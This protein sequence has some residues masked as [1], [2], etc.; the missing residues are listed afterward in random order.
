[1]PDNADLCSENK[2]RKIN[3]NFVESSFKSKPGPVRVEIG[4]KMK[5][6]SISS[7]NPNQRAAKIHLNRLVS[8]VGE[9]LDFQS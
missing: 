1:M 2:V 9:A 4:L 5:I 7:I 3:T 8:S 6:N